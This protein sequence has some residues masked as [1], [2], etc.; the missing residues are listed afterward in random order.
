M[1]KLPILAV[2][3]ILIALSPSLVAQEPKGGRPAPSARSNYTIGVEDVLRVMVWG[4]PDLDTTQKVRPDGRVTVP[5]VNDVH[6]A[7][8]STDEVRL[9]SS[10]FS[11]R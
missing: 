11:E 1:A 9:R 10:D 8:L 4:E 5:L 6:V 3:P 7:G 2:M